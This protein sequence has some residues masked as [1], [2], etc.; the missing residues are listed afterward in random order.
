MDETAF[1]RWLN[2]YGRAWENRDPAA[3][4]ELYAEEGS[5]QV[6]PFVEPMRGRTAIRDYWTGVAG[7]EK[8]VRFGYE[9]LVVTESIGIAHWHAWFEITPQGLKTRLDIIFVIELDANGKCVSL[10]EWWHKQQ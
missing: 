3:A 1:K 8:D 6:T 2:N 10:R 4:A 5:Y 7:T 9:I